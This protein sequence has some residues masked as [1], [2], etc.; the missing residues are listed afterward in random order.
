MH[1]WTIINMFKDVPSWAIYM[2]YWEL[3]S[4]VAYTLAFTLFETVLVFTPVFLIGL[5][6]PRRWMSDKYIPLMSVFL[7]EA[8]IMAVGL[9]YFTKYDLPEKKLLLAYVVVILLSAFIALKFT[10]IKVVLEKI[11]ARLVLLSLIYITFD[12]LGLLIVIVRNLSGE[13]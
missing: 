5:L 6:I 12:V 1:V 2:K 9:Q 11:S 4:S 3:I 13:S 7:I 8:A 10:R